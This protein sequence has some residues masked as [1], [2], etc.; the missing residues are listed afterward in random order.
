MGV[1]V[2]LFNVGGWLTHG[3]FAFEGGADFLAVVERGLGSVPFFMMASFAVQGTAG[4][5]CVSI[6]P[7]VLEYAACLFLIPFVFFQ[8]HDGQW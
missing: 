7:R 5:C 1:S 8:L 6:F 3:D 2:E 4:S